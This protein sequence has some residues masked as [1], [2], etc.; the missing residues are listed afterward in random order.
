MFILELVLEYTEMRIT[1]QRLLLITIIQGRQEYVLLRR[2]VIFK[3][4][5]SC[6]RFGNSGETSRSNMAYNSILHSQVNVS[7]FI[8][9]QVYCSEE[10]SREILQQIHHVGRAYYISCRKHQGQRQDLVESQYHVLMLKCTYR[11]FK[12]N[13]MGGS[14]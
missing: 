11:Y 14:I 6:C 12:R 9:K 3:K 8:L 10:N 13:S 5:R 2:I 4:N 7:L 1:N